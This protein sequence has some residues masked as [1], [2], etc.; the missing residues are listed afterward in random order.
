MLEVNRNSEMT[1]PCFFLDRVV[2]HLMILT[3]KRDTKQASEH[4]HP[5][6]QI[7]VKYKHN[8]K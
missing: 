2:H 1:L 4:Y 5:L 6:L 7:A 3:P 8:P